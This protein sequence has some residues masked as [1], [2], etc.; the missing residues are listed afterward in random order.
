MSNKSQQIT[1]PHLENTISVLMKFFDFSRQIPFKQL[2]YI[3]GIF[4]WGWLWIFFYN[5]GYF[6]RFDFS[7]IATTLIGIAIGGIFLILT[8]ALFFV[9][10][11]LVIQG[12]YT[13]VVGKKEKADSG[14]LQLKSKLFYSSAI[15]QFFSSLVFFILLIIHE[16]F[17]EMHLVWN[18][19]HILLMVMLIVQVK[20]CRGTLSKQSDEVKKLINHKPMRWGHIFLFMFWSYFWIVF[21]IFFGGSIASLLESESWS[22]LFTIGIFA[23]LF[24]ALNILAIYIKDKIKAAQLITGLVLVGIFAT[25]PINVSILKAPFRMLSLGDVKHTKIIIKPSACEYLNS[26]TKGSCDYSEDDK[27]GVVEAI[28]VS[29]IGSE[30]LLDIEGEKVSN[31]QENNKKFSSNRRG[32]IPIPNSDV[33][34]WSKKMSINAKQPQK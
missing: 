25:L 12:I 8:L 31:N 1:S 11:S 14:L 33:L 34:T 32:F 18:V 13:E 5:I 27:V 6:P 28:I 26:L 9:F 20:I 2:V 16:Y 29:R 15:W 17:K 24:G 4:G 3:G 21:L 23:I 30:F 10:P 7:T 22:E 19:L